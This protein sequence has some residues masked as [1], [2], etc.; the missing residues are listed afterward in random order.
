MLVRDVP[1]PVR[2][3]FLTR[4]R[5]GLRVLEKVCLSNYPGERSLLSK[6]GPSGGGRVHLLGTATEGEQVERL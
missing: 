2:R 5:G 4:V 1:N 6:S 3:R